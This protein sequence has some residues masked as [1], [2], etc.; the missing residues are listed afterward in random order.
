MVVAVAA[1][2]V[3][4]L[5]E[6]DGATV[7]DLQGRDFL[8]EAQEPGAGGG[9]K[10]RIA[11]ADNGVRVLEQPRRKAAELPLRAGVGSCWASRMNSAMSRWPEKSKTPG[12]GSWA[13]QKT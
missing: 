3:F 2:F 6:D 9:E 5:D 7:A 12:R 10:L 13:F 1:V 4:D 11:G 8:A